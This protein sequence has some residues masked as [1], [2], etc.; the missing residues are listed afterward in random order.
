M[1]ID[2]QI[3]DN[4]TGQLKL[5]LTGHIEQVR[6]MFNHH[7]LKVM[8]NQSWYHILSYFYLLVV[9][10]RRV[11]GWC[12]TGLAVSTRHPY[13]FSAGDD[14]QVKCWDLE[15][16]K[17]SL[18]S[19][20]SSSMHGVHAG[21]GLQLHILSAEDLTFARVCAGYPVIS[22]TFEWSVLL[23][24]PSYTGYSHDW[25][26]RLSVS[27]MLFFF[28]RRFSCFSWNVNNCELRR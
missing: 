2:V 9:I 19:S 26:T 18:L 27:G 24:A 21:V 11:D 8:I 6:G 5:T 3:W 7:T 20:Q 25:R 16:N 23:S 22:W 12:R 28:F 4:G 13:L 10:L 14:K 15:Y 1:H 17:V